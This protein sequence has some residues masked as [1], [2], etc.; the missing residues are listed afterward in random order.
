MSF[1]TAGWIT[2][3]G[4]SATDSSVTVGR[5]IQST[6]KNGTNTI[7]SGSTVTPAVDSTQ[8]INIGAGYNSAR[9]V[10][11]AAM[12]SG[13]KAA[14]SVTV[15]GTASTPT[16]ANTSSAMLQKLHLVQQKVLQLLAIQDQQEIQ[17]RSLLLEVLLLNLNF[18]MLK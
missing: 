18:I 2:T 12:S 14:A 16:L 3:G 6:L 7:A 1:S 13:T 4:A 15:S 5:I 10:V 8:T 11:I 9:T 17:L